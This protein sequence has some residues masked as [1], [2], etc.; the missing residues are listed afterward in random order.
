LRHA[1]LLRRQRSNIY[2]LGNIRRRLA[3]Q[4]CPSDF[5][6]HRQNGEFGSAEIAPTA[7]KRESPGRKG[8]TTKPVS[9]KTMRNNKPYTS[10]PCW[11]VNS[12]K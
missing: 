8:V 9:Q 12:F 3:F 5:N 11:R 2:F 4:F 10:I 1:I 7:N 6:D